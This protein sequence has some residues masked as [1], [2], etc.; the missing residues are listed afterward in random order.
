MVRLTA[1]IAAGELAEDPAIRAV[2]DA[3]GLGFLRAKRVMELA[4]LPLA[5][6]GQD[7]GEVAA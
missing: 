1:R 6:E 7:D 4:G 2:Q 3:L 5:G